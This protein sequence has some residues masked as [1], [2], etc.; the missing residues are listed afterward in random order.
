MISCTH[1]GILPYQE[2]EDSFR[3]TFNPLN[4]SGNAFAHVLTL[5][6]GGHSMA[7][8]SVDFWTL[9]ADTMQVE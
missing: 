1:L 7:E 3:V 5:R 2:M 4:H 8:Y 9:A 6:Q